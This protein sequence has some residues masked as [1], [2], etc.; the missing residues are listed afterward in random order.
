MLKNDREEFNAFT[1][2][3]DQFEIHNGVDSFKSE[4]GLTDDDFGMMSQRA[5]YVN[6]KIY[7][8]YDKNGVA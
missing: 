8:V 6:K 7:G 4:N 5:I 2:F 3:W 1:N